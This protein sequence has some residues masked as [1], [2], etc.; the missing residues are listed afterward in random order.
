MTASDDHVYLPHDPTDTQIEAAEE[1]LPSTSRQRQKVASYIDSTGDDGATDTEI[2]AALDLRPNSERPRRRE[3]VQDGTVCDSGVRRPA[4][5][6]ARASIVWITNRKAAAVPTTFNDPGPT[7]VAGP[8]PPPHVMRGPTHPDAYRIKVGRFKERWYRDPLPA[9]DIAPA[10]VNEDESYPAFS[11]IKGASGR[12][13]TYTSLKRIANAPDLDTIAKTGFFERYEKMKVINSLQLSAAQRRGTNV[14]TWAECLAYGIP[15]Y[16]TANDEGADYFGCVDQL[17]ADLNP[18]L[19]AAEFVAIHRDLNGVGYGGTSD[20]IFDIGGKLYMVDWKSRTEDG[21]HD[22]YPEEA[23]QIGSYCGAQY[24]IAE[25]DD[26]TNPH[27]AKRIPIPQLEGGLIV[28]IKPDSY[29]VYPIDIPKAIDHFAAMHAWW[30]AGRSE[31]KAIGHKWAPRRNVTV[32]PD[33]E[34]DCGEAE[35]ARREGLYDRFDKL[36]KDQ[37]EQFVQRKPN[38]DSSDLDAVEA[39]LDSIVDPPKIIDLAKQRMARDAEH[40]AARRLSAEGGPANPDDVR[41]FELRWELGMTTPGKQWVAKVVNAAIS[42]LMDFRLSQ[43]NSQ[44]R[45]DIYCALTEYATTDVFD[46]NND[47]PFLAVLNT[48]HPTNTVPPTLGFAVGNLTTEQAAAMRKLVTQ[49]ADGEMSY[50]VVPGAGP[51]WV[52]VNN[53]ANE[54]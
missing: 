53:Q 52:P 10:L 36:T 54:S 35:A 1:V 50:L 29:E 45:A 49:I 2:Q 18:I 12:D 13:W 28:S 37:Q 9:D 24:M 32:K 14:H 38:I 42:A 6:T 44:R 15:Q 4:L 7:T 27:G 23:G 31:S 26:P 43:L 25:D 30:L 20:G 16:L 48:V 46:H 3:L 5:D 47:D 39:L 8:T 33:D 21:D 17:F 11:T 34:C 40:E 51:K 41:T 19:V 22:C